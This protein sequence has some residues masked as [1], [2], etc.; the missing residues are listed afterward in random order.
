[1]SEAKARW[2]GTKHFSMG[3]LV[4]AQVLASTVLF[5]C[6][7]STKQDASQYRV[8]ELPGSVVEGTVHLRGT[9]PPPKKIRVAQDAD[10][11][12]ET[13]EV[14][15]VHVENGG[16]DDAVVWIDNI[17]AGK[18]FAFPPAQ[19]DQRD[20][21]YVPHIILMQI[22][23]LAIT[24]RDP[25]PHSVHTHAQHN[26]DYNESMSS[27]QGDI[28]VNLQQPDVISVRCDLHG[29]MQAYVIVAKNPYYA[30]TEN[31]GKFKLD[32]VPKGHYRL[33]VWSE[34]LGE[35]EEEIVVEEGKPTEAHFTLKSP[36]E[37]PAGA[38]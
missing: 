23:D 12:G 28:S 5:G 27:L 34:N 10:V 13:R 37:H 14:F 30:I 8:E 16:I 11:C 21:T 17:H 9:V 36:A 4:C 7:G 33:K 26:R 25:I 1:M 2:T 22:G 38:N 29:W 24:S 3:G 6:A 31:G 20:C 18:A 32:G 15:P 19:L 35:S